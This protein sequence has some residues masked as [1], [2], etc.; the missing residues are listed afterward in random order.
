MSRFLS[1]LL[2]AFALPASAADRADILVADFEGEKYTDGW[3]TTGTAFGDGP[4]KGA[5]PGQMA[6]T[7]FLGKG[8]VNSFK[9]GDDAIGTLTS[10]E[11]ELDRKFV[12]FLIGGGKHPG[13]ACINLIIDGKAVR[14]ATGPNDKPGGTEHLDWQTWDVTEFAGKTATIQIVDEQKGGWGHINIDHIVQSDKKKQAEQMARMIEVDQRY[15]HLPV[16]T[17]ATMRRVSFTIRHD[18]RPKREQVRDE[19]VREFDIELADGV[20]P[21]FWAFADVSAFNGNTLTVRA[22]LPGGSTALKAI[23]LS[24]EVPN[25][26]KLYREKHRP[27]FHFT[28]RFGWLND[29]NGLV[30]HNDE[31]HLFY[32][33]NPFGVNWG[34]MHWG[35]A[36]SKDLFRWKE[37]GIGLYP[38]KYG[39]MAFSGSAVV[40]KGNTSGWGS[41]E[42]PPLVLAYTSTGRGECIAFSTDDGRTWTEHDKNPVLKHSGRDPKLLWYEKGKHWVMAVYDEFQGKQWIAFHTSKDLK[43]WSF[44]SRIEG[45][46][47]CP[48]LF[49]MGTD[50]FAKDARRW[51]LYAAD[52][53]YLVGDFDGKEF[54]PDFKE[55]RQLW[56]GN[57]YAAQTFDSA[58]EKSLVDGPSPALPLFP[59]RVQIGWANGVSFPGMPFNQQMTVPVDLKLDP[60]GRLSAKPVNELFRLLDKHLMHEKEKTYRTGAKVLEA[61]AGPAFDLECELDLTSMASG[62]FKLHGTSLSYDVKKGLLT[63]KNVSAPVKPAGDVLKLRVLVDRGSIEVFADEGRV[64]M[65][66]AAIQ[67]EKGPGVEVIVVGGDL[68]VKNLRISRLL[69]AWEK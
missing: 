22:M 47:E 63:C 69:S 32:Q 66:V 43:E 12:N 61:E 64:A 68:K 40:D 10:P 28:S 49:D 13:K 31:W 65:S 23:K 14:T 38:R 29:P 42:K 1:L 34:N 41:K 30:R 51:V 59:R 54:K 18:V 55:K 46:F 7:G 67:A 25:S 37:L 44:A 15:L 5:L 8:L 33:H 6:V 21:D 50:V 36:V 11:F 35:H 62:G 39:D 16:K 52:G 60:S 26:E 2:L 27:L 56:Y 53:K 3:K 20:E 4:A 17:G 48:D 19:I 24:P 9:G 58:G 57:F 45:F